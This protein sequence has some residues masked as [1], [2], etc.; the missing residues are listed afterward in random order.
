MPTETGRNVE[1]KKVPPPRSSGGQPRNPLGMGEGYLLLA[2]IL[3]GFVSHAYN[4]FQYPLYLGDEGIYMEQAWAILREGK[5]APYTYFYDHAPGGWILL[6]AWE[7]LLPKQFLTWGMAINSGRVLM[8]MLHVASVYL[9]FKVTRSLSGSPTAALMVCLIFSLSP[10]GLYYQRMVLLDNIMVFWLLLSIHLL[11]DNRGRLLVMLV[12]GVA[13]GAALVTKENAIFFAPVLSYILYVQ[14]KGTYRTRFAVAGWAFTWCAVTSVYPLYAM[15]K[16]ELLPAGT[17]VFTGRPGEH[18]SLISTVLWQLSRGG[19]SIFDP[20]SRFWYFWNGFW[21]PKDAFILAGGG[22]ATLVALGIG[23]ASYRREKGLLM[24]GLLSLSFAFYL[25]RGSE[26]LAFYVVPLLPFLAMTIGMLMDKA[27]Q[28]LPARLVGGACVLAML[29]LAGMFLSLSR[30]HYTLN[31]TQEQI[32]QL[33]FIRENIPSNARIVIDDDLWVDLHE[34]NGEQAVFPYAHSH[35]KV[36]G[37]PE[38]RDRLLDGNWRN[39]DYL[40]LSDDLIDT[41]NYSNEQFVLA[42]YQNSRLIAQFEK[43]D[44]L[45][46]VRQVNK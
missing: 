5:L 31:L 27:L 3:I 20:Y 45:V 1:E 34:R 42:A 37:D 38:I 44:V 12:S 16:G 7:L 9:L 21:W 33:Q 36:E 8:V 40:V 41:F 22:L 26:M 43:G 25:T 14:V 13:F 18:V 11:I 17:L 28:A 10:L 4:M 32:Q 2:A 39:I 29:S 23:I 19:G 15:L 24:A 30:D 35:W 6:A 46:Q